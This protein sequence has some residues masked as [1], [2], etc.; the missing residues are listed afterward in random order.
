MQLGVVHYI[1]KPFTFTTLRDRLENYA[2]ARKRLADMKHADQRDID[3][4]HDT[5]SQVIVPSKLA[6]LLANIAPGQHKHGVAL[7]DR[8][9]HK[10]V[11]GL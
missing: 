1:V 8:M 5:G 11:L 6:K 3:R 9:A 10:R 4:L 2:T 7:L